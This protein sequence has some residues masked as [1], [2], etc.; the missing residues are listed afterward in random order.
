MKVQEGIAALKDWFWIHGR[1]RTGEYALAGEW[2]DNLY[3]LQDEATSTARALESSKPC[4]ALW[5]PS[6]T[7]KS[8][9]LSSYIDHPSTNTVCSILQWLPGSPVVFSPRE[10]IPSQSVILN[11]HNFGSDASGCATRFTLR[12]ALPDPQH[13]V[14]LT[15]ANEKQI[16][17]A[18]ATGYITECNTR[19]SAG[20]D[21]TLSPEAILQQL[22][23]LT[24]G[25][26][27]AQLSRS[28]RESLQC[29]A[30][31]LGSLIADDWQ[32]YR[33]LKAEW[34]GLRARLLPGRL[35]GR[36]IERGVR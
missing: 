33:P 17:Y 25:I 23:N 18:L 16:L 28:G 21:R 2:L 32:R 11:P 36:L 1:L 27:S 4:L 5:G 20:T 10:N 22:E 19:T 6:Q 30:D 3:R 15:L 9:L 14:E 8:T 7:G 12:D 34:P 31:V 26:T 29:I 35:A 24:H 13:P